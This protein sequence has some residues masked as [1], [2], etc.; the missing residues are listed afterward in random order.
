MISM[1]KRNQWMFDHRLNIRFGSEGFAKG[2]HLGYNT[3]DISNGKQPVI[4]FN[5]LIDTGRKQRA[6]LQGNASTIGPTLVSSF[7]TLSKLNNVSFAVRFDSYKKESWSRCSD[8]ERRHNTSRRWVHIHFIYSLDER[9]IKDT[10]LTIIPNI[11]SIPRQLRESL[12][13]YR[14]RLMSLWNIKRNVSMIMDLWLF[15]SGQNAVLSET[16]EKEMTR[17]NESICNG[18]RWVL[19][20]LQI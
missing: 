4:S 6:F 2:I 18:M 15:H 5:G 7:E 1:N 19:M 13:R 11:P 20:D 14:F 10:I 17:G 16:N 9:R 12:F 8:W 3:T